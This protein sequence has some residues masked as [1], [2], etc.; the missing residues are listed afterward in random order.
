MSMLDMLSDKAC[1]ERFYQYKLD[2]ACPKQFA[3]R[4]REF[5]DTE[6]YLPVCRRINAGETFPL[7]RR[8]VISKLDTG[9]KRVIYIYPE[10]ENTVL[11]LLTHLLLRHYDSIFSEGLYSFRPGHT[12]QMALRRLCRIPG[13]E[14]RWCYKADISNYFNSIDISKLLPELKAVTAGDP[15]L[16]R[17]LSSLLLEPCVLSEG[18][19]ISEQKGIM[20]GT[21]LS[22][23]YADLFLRELDEHFEAAGV[24]YARYSDDIILFAGSKQEAEVHAAYMKT[25][26][27]EKGLQINPDKE[28]YAAPGELWVFLGLCFHAG[29]LD[30]APASLKKLKAKMRRKARALMRWQQ[31]SALPGEKAAA[32]FIRI[33]NR[34]LFEAGADNQLSWAY[35]Y[36]PIINTDQ[37]LR[38]IDRY[39]QDCLRWLISGRRTKA[40]FNVTYSRLKALG[41][42]S[43][44]NEYYKSRSKPTAEK[45]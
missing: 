8:A 36:F 32:A 26:L 40:R 34:K 4:L 30:I 14:S 9:K 29:K 17:F 27:A 22:A 7:P 3:K 21:P 33:F 2:L 31:R 44:V 6:G 1:W 18:Q 12:A 16:Y 20:A 38:Q 43:C 11:K 28:S 41:Y 5:I 39:S 37:S 45:K 15:R 23:F 24:P 42:R 13:L 19:P 10:P 35:W 25:C